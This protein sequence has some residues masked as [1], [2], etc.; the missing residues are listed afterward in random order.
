[1]NKLTQAILEI[2]L[3]HDFSVAILTKSSLIIRD[4]DLVK[5]FSD[6]EAGLTITT[7]NK[8]VAKDFEPFASFPEQ[9]VRALKELRK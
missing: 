1:L 8:E 2:L 4:I 7:L 3:K 9:R 6:C 5:Q